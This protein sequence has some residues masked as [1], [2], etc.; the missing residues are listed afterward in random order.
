[1]SPGGVHYCH[2][3]RLN[4]FQMKGS[5]LRILAGRG[6]PG[7]S[8]VEKVTFLRR[9]PGADRVLCRPSLVMPFDFQAQPL[10]DP[11][12]FRL[13]WSVE[14]RVRKPPARK[15]FGNVA[16]AINSAPTPA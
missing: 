6:A 14:R 8:S 9:L 10:E 15:P 4:S 7:S 11:P 12:Q 13:L 3:T 1:M 16:L 5:R 2:D